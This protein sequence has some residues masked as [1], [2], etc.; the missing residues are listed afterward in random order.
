MDVGTGAYGSKGEGTAV[1]TFEQAFL[2][3]DT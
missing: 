1:G 2:L 3:E